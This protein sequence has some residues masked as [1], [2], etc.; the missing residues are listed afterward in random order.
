MPNVSD[1]RDKTRRE[2]LAAVLE[3]SASDAEF[4]AG[5]LSDPKRAIADAFGVQIPDSF[6]LRFI[7]KGPDLDSLVVLPN[8]RDANAELDVSALDAVS[9]GQD[10][11]SGELTDDMDG[12]FGGPSPW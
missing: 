2:L 12:V 7:E 6:R 9:G 8:V 3:R 1:A 10:P 11:E 5:L 4:R